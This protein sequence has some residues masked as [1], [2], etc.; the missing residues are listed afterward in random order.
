MAPKIGAEGVG[1]GLA[2][3]NA[4]GTGMVPSALAR[5]G[6]TDDESAGDGSKKSGSSKRGGAAA[7]SSSADHPNALTFGPA[8]SASGKR[9]ET[10]RCTRWAELLC[11]RPSTGD[12]NAMSA[13][14]LEVLAVSDLEKPLGAKGTGNTDGDGSAT[15]IDKSNVATK[16]ANGNDGVA[17]VAPP[18]VTA[19]EVL[20][21]DSAGTSVPTKE[22]SPEDGKEDAVTVSVA[23]GMCIDAPEVAPPKEC[24]DDLAT[25]PP[26]GELSK[27]RERSDEAA[28]TKE[29]GEVDTKKAKTCEG[30][31]QTEEA[32]KGT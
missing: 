6:D 20:E 21:G 4:G 27:K 19:K 16:M 26:R 12:S 22:D 14:L 15:C 8:T 9:I 28:P 10:E 11:N 30:E 31:K 5:G 18:A 32:Q 1:S 25:D 3:T 17:P 7:L 29:G 13:W 23:G 2:T 24:G